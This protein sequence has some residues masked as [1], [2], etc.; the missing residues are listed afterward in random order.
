MG[1]LGRNDP[2]WCG[3]GKKYKD[4]H[5][6][7]DQAPSPAAHL[8]ALDEQVL[9]GILAYASDRFPDRLSVV[10]RSYEALVAGE[11]DAD[12]HSVLVIPWCLYEAR[13]RGRRLVEWYLAER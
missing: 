10:L 2:C 6:E 11:P 1:Q 4:C 8:H 12:E 9:K 7:S 3:R 5:R 13:F